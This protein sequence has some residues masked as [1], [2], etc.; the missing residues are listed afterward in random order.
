M[1]GGVAGWLTPGW[2]SHERKLSPHISTPGIFLSPHRPSSLRKANAEGRR[3]PK[4]LSDRG[5]QAPLHALEGQA[6]ALRGSVRENHK[7]QSYQDLPVPDE[8]LRQLH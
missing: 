7:D 6:R 1:G 3:E 2:M 4:G 5:M 8:R